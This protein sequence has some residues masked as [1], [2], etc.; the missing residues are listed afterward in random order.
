MKKSI[1]YLLFIFAISAFTANIVF[2]SNPIP[3]ID[4]IVKKKCYPVRPGCVSFVVASLKTDETGKFS[5]K[6]E[7]GNY[8]LAFSYEQIKRVLGD[9]D[10]SNRFTLEIDLMFVQQTPNVK[11][12]AKV[13]INK[14]T[15]PIS[16]SVAKGGGTLSGTLT[17]TLKG[18]KR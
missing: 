7:E 5:C 17:Y 10:L 9:F 6:L 15:G 2:A 13:L 12:P 16:I 14:E 4:V 8:E 1:I 18:S 3:G 11:A